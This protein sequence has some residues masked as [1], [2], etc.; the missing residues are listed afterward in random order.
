MERQIKFRAFDNGVM[1]KFLRIP[2][3]I[4]ADGT[5]Y[6]DNDPHGVD[7]SGKR[8]V[9]PLQNCEIMQYTGLKDKNGKDVYEGDI[10]RIL[11]TDWPSKSGT[12]PR[13]IE[14]YMIDIAKVGVIE[15]L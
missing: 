15:Y 7:M 10:V 1:K 12:D 11:Y 3:Y 8:S 14:Q 9:S 5:V 4:G 2:F 13:T 6:K